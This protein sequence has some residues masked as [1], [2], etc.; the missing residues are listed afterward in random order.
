[1]LLEVRYL[2]FKVRLVMKKKFIGIP[3]LV[4]YKNLI[5]KNCP[6]IFM[7]PNFKLFSRMNYLKIRLS[8]LMKI[9]VR[10]HHINLMD[11]EILEILAICN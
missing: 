9:Y 5:K 10:K 3:I 11:S 8:R 4:L 1:M 7:N 6:K 2:P